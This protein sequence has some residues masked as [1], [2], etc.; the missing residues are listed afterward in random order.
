MRHNN[1]YDVGLVSALVPLEDV[2]G[3]GETPGDFVQYLHEILGYELGVLDNI[4]DL[5]LLSEFLL[6][7][8]INRV[9]DDAQRLILH[10]LGLF[11]EFEHVVSLFNNLNRSY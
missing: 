2:V 4:H 10:I 7:S 9:V 8:L 1:L 6:K 5:L 11:L 3:G